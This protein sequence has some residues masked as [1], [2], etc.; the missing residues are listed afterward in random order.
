[1]LDHSCQVQRHPLAERGDDLYETPPV[2]VEALLRVEHL[3]RRIWEPACGPGAIVRVLRAHGHEVLAS[4]LVDYGNPT[5]KLPVFAGMNLLEAEQI[6]ADI[7][8]R[9]I[10]AACVEKS[11]QAVAQNSTGPPNEAAGRKLPSAG[12]CVSKE[13]GD[14]NARYQL[15]G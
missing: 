8:Q 14:A 1:M 6:I 10:E 2:A 15:P 9:E 5:H 7:L 4:D 13:K 3:P 12:N 11:E